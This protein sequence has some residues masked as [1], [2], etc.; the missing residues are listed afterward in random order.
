MS[1]FFSDVR[2]GILAFRLSGS[3]ETA[4]HALENAR[5]DGPPGLV[6]C[7]SLVVGLL[8][9]SMHGKRHRIV[10]KRFLS[11]DTRFGRFVGSAGAAY[12]IPE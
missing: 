11:C 12:V 5:I 9:P 8:P 10:A 7:F 6:R 4:R 1:K 2:V 3:F